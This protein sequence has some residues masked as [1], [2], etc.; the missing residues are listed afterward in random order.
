MSNKIQVL[1]NIQ[2]ANNYLLSQQVQL[3]QTNAMIHSIGLGCM[4]MS[5]NYGKRPSEEDSI[6][7]I[8][9]ALELGCN[10]FDTARAYGGGHNEELLGKAIK[11]AIAAGKIKRE[12]VV[13]AT[14]FGVP[15]ENSG[16]PEYVRQ[17]AEESLKR[18][19]LGYIDLLYQHRVDRN[20]PIEDIIRVV[21]ELI[22]E[23]K[24]KYIGLSEAAPD[25]IRRAHAIHPITALQTEYSLWSIDPELNDTLA[26]CRELGITFVAYSPLGRG[27]LTGSIKSWD[28]FEP[29]DRR[30]ELPRFAPENFDKNLLLVE[31]IKK[32]AQKKNCTPGQLALAWV[33]NQPG[34]VAIPGTT[35]VANLEENMEAAKVHISEDDEKEIRTLLEKAVI[36]GQ[37]YEPSA[38]KSVHL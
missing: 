12:D 4:G 7:A 2:T 28:E 27:F 16:G 9:R 3:G 11:S 26:T 32:L 19:D 14:K 10:F 34:V 6:K 15:K 36:A 24:V 13:I 29:N 35:R 30:R 23:G 25:T 33:L 21:A 22:K 38:M 5:M 1:S 37:R 8:H 20:I 31:E 17:M 18:L